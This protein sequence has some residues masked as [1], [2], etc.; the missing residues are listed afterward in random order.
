MGLFAKT[1][2]R[3]SRR[4]SKRLPDKREGIPGPSDNPATNFLIADVVIRAG[5]YLARRG[6][7]KRLLSNRYGR[8]TAHRIVENKS[9]GQ[10][11]L[12]FA[13]ARVA[14]KSV[15]G[16]ILV[17]GGALA[18]ALLDRRKSRLQSKVEGDAQLLQQAADE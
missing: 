8:D 16:A 9:L 14:S 4:L 10:T 7:E 18:K 6:F 17:G 15:P 13:L 12:S 3:P 5:G 2:R 1:A 11:F